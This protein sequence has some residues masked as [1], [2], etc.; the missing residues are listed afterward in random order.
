M[1]KIILICLVILSLAIP[2]QAQS[3]VLAFPGAEG[4]GAKTAGGRGGAIIE[5]TNL[6]NSGAG[7]LR[8]CIDATGA[9]T[10]VFR[11][12]GLIS[13]SSS[14]IIKNPY[15]TIAGQT[16]P[17]GGVTLK[18]I[19][20]A[21]DPLLD[22]YTHDVIVR[23]LTFRAGPPAAGD[24]VNVTGINN[25]TYNIVLD[26]NSMS[27]GVDQVFATW[28]DVRDISIQ[29]NI[30]SE[31]LDCSI[32]D[33]GCH[34]KGPMLGSYAS[35]ES[36]DKP[37][38]GNIS[39]HHNLSAHNGERN[40]LVKTSGITD[41]VNNVSY[42]MFGNSSHVDMEHQ[43]AEIPVNYVGNYFKPGLDT[44]PGKYGID[45]SNVGSLGAEIY[46]KGNIGYRRPNDTLPEIN[47]VDPAARP[48]I[49][50]AR[51]P[52]PLITTTSAEVAYSE[53]LAKAGANIG[54][55]CD[56]SLFSRRDS[57]D[58]RVVNDVRNG[59]GR[60]I[61]NPSE[62]GGWI[63]PAAGTPC[64]DSDKDGMPDTWEST[65][66]FNPAVKDN[67]L[68]K[69]SDGY[70]NVEE[71]LNGTDPGGA[72][73]PTNTPTQTAVI[74]PTATFTA[75]NT[76][77]VTKTRT[78]TPTRTFTQTPTQTPT[79][80]RTPTPTRTFTPTATRTATNTPIV[81]PTVEM[82]CFEDSQIRLCYLLK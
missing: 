38:A 60:I 8:A 74:V 28:Y 73:G 67:N 39:F 33:K 26:H 41:V 82:T 69:D 46:I 25:Q 12:A 64:T 53:V 79:G 55:S 70:T 78:P 2:V 51:H 7:S 4:F 48:Y 30:F 10:C 58:T 31:A 62:V 71:Y 16:A 34:S 68:D 17:G 13:L 32:H 18:D 35:D 61:D 19:S 65:Y 15:I 11:V 3:G 66:G 22:I 20:A 29:W 36:K 40:P 23:Y 50:S 56:G 47:I 21:T 27:W 59:T 44:T 43:L 80:T 52:A 5:V 9:R 1:K 54:V 24:A 72:A 14:L 63:T 81:T 37:G 75:T 77:T 76:P 6:N 57:I 45:V 49:V 42:N